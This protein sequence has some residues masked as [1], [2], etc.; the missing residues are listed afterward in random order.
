VIGVFGSDPERLARH[1]RELAPEESVATFSSAAELARGGTALEAVVGWGMPVA[2]LATLPNL[3]LV[4][5]AAAGVESLLRQPLPERVRIA[6]IVDQFGPPM[7]EYV[8]GHLLAR[9][10]RHAALAEAQRERRWARDLVPQRLFGQRLT[11]AGLGSIG[12]AVVRLAAVF[13]MSV[14]GY[15]RTGAAARDLPL[16]RHFQA[17]PGALA[18]AVEGADALVTVMPITPET[19]HVVDRAV[20][21]ALGPSGILINIGRGALVD[22]AALIDALAKGE[23][24][25]AVLDVFETEPLPPDSPLWTLPGVTVT[26]HISGRTRMEETARTFLENVRRV[27][28]GLPPIGEV[29]RARG[30]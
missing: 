5:Q 22:E 26:P 10:Q 30:Y 20:L 4:Q 1:V 12:G 16:E 6:R 28:V 2:V 27:R 21:R 19:H 24:G 8:F 17:A 9:S 18:A 25:G 13:G 3:T 23:L 14:T 7:S 11:V 15:S 29:D